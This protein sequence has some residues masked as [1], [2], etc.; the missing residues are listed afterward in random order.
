[1]LGL[2]VCE[3]WATTH[4]C[5]TRDAREKPDC[6]SGGGRIG[7]DTDI[8]S[9]W[10]EWYINLGQEASELRTTH[11]LW[12]KIL[13]CWWRTVVGLVVHDIRQT[14]LAGKMIKRSL[15]RRAVVGSELYSNKLESVCRN[16]IDVAQADCRD[17]FQVAWYFG[18][19]WSWRIATIFHTR[20]KVM[21]RE[22]RG[23]E[24]VEEK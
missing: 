16:K 21:L 13:W 17:H 18:D 20:E 10:C 8:A 19:G 5:E 7:I 15:D 11:H 14:L 4:L 3:L 22:R 1:M 12:N 6:R 23:C 2:V 9:F 24:I